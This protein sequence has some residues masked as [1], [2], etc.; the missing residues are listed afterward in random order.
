MHSDTLLQRS[1]PQPFELVNP[2]GKAPLILFCDHAGRAVPKQLGDL[3]LSAAFF[4]KHIAWDIG[5]GDLGRHLSALLDAPL[6]LCGYSRLVIDC[7]RHLDDPTSIPQ[8]SDQIEIPGNRGLSV[9]QRQ[10]RAAEIFTP[11]HQ[12]LDQ[13][14]DAKLA[15]GQRPV[16]LSLHSFTPLMNGFQRPWHIG[17]LWNKDARL[18]MPLMRRFAAEP[19]VVVGDNE[20]YSGRDGHGYS[21]KYHAEA[22]G[23]SHALIEVRQDLIADRAG[24]ERWTEIVQRV[25]HDVLAEVTLYHPAPPAR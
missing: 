17:I 7:N 3:G 19:G 24:V 8:I 5:I 23:L 18:P 1:D 21:M 20:P 2:G 10:Q 11:Y 9:Q 22:R 13:L 25:C 15:A 4:D 12:A 16:L 6:L 14:T